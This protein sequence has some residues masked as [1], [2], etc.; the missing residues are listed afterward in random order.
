MSVARNFLD[1]RHPQHRARSASLRGPRR[2]RTELV[3][4]ELMTELSGPGWAGRPGAGRG[5]GRAEGNAPEG[6]GGGG[7]AAL[8]PG[9]R[10]ACSDGRGR[11]TRTMALG[12]LRPLPRLLVLGLGLA[13]L[14]AAGGERVPGTP[15]AGWAGGRGGPGSLSPGIGEPAL[16][17]RRTG[18]NLGGSR[19]TRGFGVRC[20]PDTALPGPE[21][22]IPLRT[23]SAVSASVSPI[24]NGGKASVLI[25]PDSE[26]EGKR[27]FEG[28]ISRSVR[29][30]APIVSS[31]WF[32]LAP[33]TEESLGGGIED[34]G[35]GTPYT[36]WG[37]PF[38]PVTSVPSYAGGGTGVGPG[39]QE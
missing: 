3:L 26:V 30:H 7:A 1:F 39:A 36:M 4:F 14:G 16:G 31:T 17:T 2:R 12:P 21:R 33:L 20:S 38:H 5:A 28:R 13:L 22:F 15:G 11:R 29:R 25:S 24:S 18:P 37:A 8:R 6:G 34:T 10:A 9:P 27:K 32:C 23:S 35:V 19:R